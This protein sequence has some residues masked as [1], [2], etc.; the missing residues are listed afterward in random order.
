[1]PDPMHFEKCF[2]CNQAFEFGPRVFGGRRIPEWDLMVC[3]SC[4]ESNWDG[5]I[6]EARPT[7]VPYLLV[8]TARRAQFCARARRCPSRLSA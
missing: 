1:M 7:L 4:H 5:I 8:R 6:P 3:M 2:L